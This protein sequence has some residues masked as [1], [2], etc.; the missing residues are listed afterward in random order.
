M[1][2]V[3][4]LSLL[5]LNSVMTSA[6]DGGECP[7]GTN[8]LWNNLVGNLDQMFWTPFLDSYSA[9]RYATEERPLQPGTALLLQDKV[10]RSCKDIGITRFMDVI[11][12]QLAALFGWQRPCSFWA[13][14]ALLTTTATLL[15][16]PKQT[17]ASNEVVKKSLNHT[18]QKRQHC[19][20]ATRALQC[21]MLHLHWVVP[22]LMATVVVAFLVAALFGSLACF[23]CCL[24]AK[25]G[26]DDNFN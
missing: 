19:L 1:K 17:W 13:H 22:Q 7:A 23:C 21:S 20:Y 24:C 26:E 9:V 4:L 3:L 25:R 16:C 2:R 11:C 14:P 18:L 15:E 10:P 5:L 8:S 6:E 12:V